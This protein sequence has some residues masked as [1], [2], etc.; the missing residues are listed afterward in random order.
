MPNPIPKA[1]ALKVLPYQKEL[2]IMEQKT[3]LD[4]S[5]LYY[6][7]MTRD[8]AQWDFKDLPSKTYQAVLMNPP[9]SGTFTVKDLVGILFY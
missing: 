9:W 3:N 8:I 1:W 4:E 7:Y 5:E 6:G 2:N